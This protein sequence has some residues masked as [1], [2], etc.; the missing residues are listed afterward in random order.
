MQWQQRDLQVLS[1]ASSHPHRIESTPI[2]FHDEEV[3]NFSFL[4]PGTSSNNKRPVLKNCCQMTSDDKINTKISSMKWLYFFITKER[5]NFHFTDCWSCFCWD[6]IE[7]E[8]FF[9]WSIYT[10]HSKISF[11]QVML[12]QRWFDKSIQRNHKCYSSK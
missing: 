12:T 2:M 7:H 10:V 4:G 9:I 8:V 6:I 5:V 11:C 1:T 3:Y